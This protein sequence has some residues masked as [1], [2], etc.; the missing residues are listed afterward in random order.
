MQ[1]ASSGPFIIEA[2]FHIKTDLGEGK[3]MC[4]IYRQNNFT[5]KD[6][7]KYTFRVFQVDGS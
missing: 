6:N 4:L 7:E 2:A 5:Y 3:R 1:C